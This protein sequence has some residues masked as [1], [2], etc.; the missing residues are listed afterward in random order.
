[1]NLKVLMEPT[2]F[3]VGIDVAKAKLDVTVSP[4]EPIVTVDNMNTGLRR[5]LP[6]LHHGRPTRIMVKVTGGWEQLVIRL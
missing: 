3:C 5:L 6:P 2:L 4:T 1:M